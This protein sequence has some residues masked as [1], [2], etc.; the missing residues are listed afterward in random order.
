MKLHDNSYCLI[1]R[2]IHL[3]YNPCAGGLIRKNVPRLARAIAVLRECGHTVV[4]RPTTCAGDATALTRSSVRDG[5]DLILVAGG[6]GTINEVLNGM[7]HSDTPMAVL[8]A[9]TANVLARELGLGVSLR[10]AARR[11][12]ELV[13]ARISVGLL[14]AAGAP[15]RHFLLMAGAG[16]DAAIVSDVQPEFKKRIGK[17]AYWLAGFS[18]IRRR[19]PQLEVVAEEWTCRTGFAL[20][21]RVRNY[22][23]DLE[24]AQQV[25]ILDDDFEVVAFEGEDA[26]SYLKYLGGLIVGNLPSVPGVHMKR[27]RQ[28][29]FLA[30]EGALVGVQVDG[31]LAGHLPATVAVV[32]DGLTL[33]IPPGLEER[34]RFTTR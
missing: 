16:L 4:E 13:P 32:P 30:P 14:Q 15:A 1:Y 3:I 29:E 31:E 11:L 22:G 28:V 25:T 21:S 18:Q 34:Y 5:A 23:G 27:A 33:L 7:V 9:G 2:N 24:I 12:S 19:L 8:P 17:L 20:S 10:R 6:D 26:V